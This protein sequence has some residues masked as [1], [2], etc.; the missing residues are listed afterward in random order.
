M[1]PH[2]AYSRPLDAVSAFGVVVYGNGGMNTTY[3]SKDTTL[4]LGTY[5][6]AQSTPPD[7]STGVDLRQIGINLNYSRKLREDLSVGAGLILANQS[8]KAKGLS[9]L[10]DLAA[11]GVAD[12]LSNRGRDS[13]FG[14]GPSLASSGVHPSRSRSA[15]PIKPRSISTVLM[16]IRISSPTKAIWMRRHFSISASPSSPAPISPWPLT[17]NTSGIARSRPSAMR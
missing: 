6:G 5:G 14:W 16:S 7:A 12:H 13:V 10:G 9:A 11:D 3:R 15:R 4:H 2:L 1:I 17:S 8:F